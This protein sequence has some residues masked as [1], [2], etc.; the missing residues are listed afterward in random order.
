MVQELTKTTQ[1]LIEVM[2]IA[3][4]SGLDLSH[5]AKHLQVRVQVGTSY[6]LEIGKIRALKHL[7]AN[8]LRDLSIEGGTL[9]GIDA[10]L[11]PQAYSED[12]HTNKIR[13]TCMAMSAV[14]AGVDRLTVLPSDGEE[15]A[16]AD[17]FSRRVAR[18]VQ[19]VLMLESHL[20][21]VVDPAAGSYYLEN[22]TQQLAVK[23][24]EKV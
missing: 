9:P 19:H 4:L 14:I 7:M 16:K 18:N 8:A 6:F 13:A 23:A 21:H 12:I 15:G 3:R 1:R 22:L 11:A 2:E 17:D 10:Y 24:W 5:F 20:D